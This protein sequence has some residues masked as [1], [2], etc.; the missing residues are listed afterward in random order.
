MLWYSNTCTRSLTRAVTIFVQTKLKAAGKRGEGRGKE[1]EEERVR[2]TR[3]RVRVINGNL[4]VP[5]YKPKS[6][7][8]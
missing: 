2:R 7:Y 1:E 3:E 4:K 8:V 5:V 6:T